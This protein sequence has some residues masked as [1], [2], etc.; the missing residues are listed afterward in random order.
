MYSWE[1]SPRAFIQEKL[2][3][4]VVVADYSGVVWPEADIFDCS[5][6]AHLVILVIW[7]WRSYVG[8]S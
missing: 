4:S 1:Q 5:I 7:L 6:V 2:G 3:E 8:I